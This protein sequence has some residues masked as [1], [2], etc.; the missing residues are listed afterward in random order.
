MG[1]VITHEKRMIM[2]QLNKRNCLDD[3]II[4]NVKLN[5]RAGV[6]IN[7]QSLVPDITD[8]V[9]DEVVKNKKIGNA[10]KKFLEI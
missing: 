2:F 4:G 10:Y 1:K 3:K 6:I 9:E 5:I 7:V 8:R